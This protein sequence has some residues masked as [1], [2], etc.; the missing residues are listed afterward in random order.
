MHEH[1]SW[2][3]Q[4][5]GAIGEWFGEFSALL[6]LFDRK[7]VSEAIAPSVLAGLRAIE[8]KL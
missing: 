3:R 6:T 8:L 1:E 2:L 4:K 5:F 7:P